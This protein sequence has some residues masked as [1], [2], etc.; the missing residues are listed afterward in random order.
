V[1]SVHYRQNT[2]MLVMRQSREWVGN[3]CKPCGKRWFWKTTLHNMFLGWWGTISLVLTPFFIIGNI[4]SL[5]GVLRLPDV[6][7]LNQSQLASQREYAR[8]L[9]ATKDRAT[10]VDILVKNSG[11]SNA[12]VE[13]FLDDIQPEAAAV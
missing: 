5:F 2:G 12:E 13:A 6:A 11:A 9:L 10:V 1:A 4:S 3:A 8:N 7:A